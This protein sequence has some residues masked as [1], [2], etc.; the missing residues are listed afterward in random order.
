MT[1]VEFSVYAFAFYA[2]RKCPKKET[3]SLILAFDH[4]VDQFNEKQRTFMAYEFALTH[5]S[6]GWDHSDLW[7]EFFERNKFP[8]NPITYI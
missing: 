2:T 6:S 4:L 5:Y 8:Y 7:I 3:V 1:R